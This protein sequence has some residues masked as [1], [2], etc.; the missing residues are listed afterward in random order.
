LVKLSQQ[1]RFWA[2][3]WN[4]PQTQT[5]KISLAATFQYLARKRLI[6]GSQS[7]SASFQI[8]G[9]WD[10]TIIVVDTLPI[11]LYTSICVTLWR[12]RS[13]RISVKEIYPQLAVVWH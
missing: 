4:Q 5:R 3:M 6:I 9:K 13:W 1:F 12:I 7:R 10:R 8:W 11:L 2:Q